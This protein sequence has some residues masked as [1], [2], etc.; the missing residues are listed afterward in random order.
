LRQNSTLTPIIFLTGESAAPDPRLAQR[1]RSEI[2]FLVQRSDLELLRSKVR[3]FVELHRQRRE[4]ERLTALRERERRISRERVQILAAV[5]ARLSRLLTFDEV[6]QVVTTEAHDALAASTSE[7][8]VLA[9]GG[10]RLVLIARRAPGAQ[11]QS[12]AELAGEQ[13]PALV[14]RAMQQG[15][16]V[17]VGDREGSAGVPSEAASRGERAFVALPLS[18]GTTEKPSIPSGAFTPA[19][20]AAVGRKSQCAAT[21]SVV[22]PAAILPGQRAI[23]G[24]RMPPSVRSR[25]IPRSGP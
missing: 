5:G 13:L 25:L 12:K 17:W 6:A 3:V 8:Y 14:Q 18:V 24:S 21:W 7:L 15:E 19:S 1:D 20:S 4:L 10:S 16:P 9:E 22:F 2:D 11:R 23:I